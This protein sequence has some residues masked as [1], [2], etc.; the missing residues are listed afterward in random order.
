M[1]LGDSLLE[2]IYAGIDHSSFLIVVISAES[3]ESKW[4]QKELKAAMIKED[5]GE[6]PF[7]LPLKL[8]SVDFPLMIADKVYADFSISYVKGFEQLVRFLEKRSAR[9]L[10]IPAEKRI[11]P[12]VFARDVFLDEFRLGDVITTWR[13]VYGSTPT[14]E[15]VWVQPDDKYPQL[16]QALSSRIDSANSD[17]AWTY[18]S[19]RFLQM[20]YRRVLRLEVALGR[21]LVEII[22]HWPETEYP[23][24][25]LTSASHNFAK[26]VQSELFGILFSV[27]RPDQPIFSDPSEFWFQ[28]PLDP[29]ALG[30]LLGLK[31]PGRIDVGEPTSI[32]HEVA[33]DTGDGFSV[34]ASGDRCEQIR[35]YW[36]P[37]RLDQVFD[38]HEVTGIILPQILYK[39]LVH[40][41]Q[42]AISWA[43]RNLFCGVH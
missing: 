11:F 36:V 31:G 14:P 42:P 32:R 26:L 17:R 30:I 13:N 2:H 16:R 25:Y 24:A 3:L 20:C 40:D 33:S 37:Q 1:G 34:Y 35:R 38:P 7:V 4:V 22:L 28:Y 23:D 5:R 43:L 19:E 39:S 18:E 21:G 15:Q 41:N 27:Q 29:E 10:A 12:V 6:G 9:Q 8:G